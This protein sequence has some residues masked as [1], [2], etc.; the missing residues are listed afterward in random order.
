[1]TSESSIL[2]LAVIGFHHK[3]GYQ[4]GETRHIFRIPEFP[5]KWFRRTIS[6]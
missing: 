4:V 2:H 3:K 6:G 1:M 5:L